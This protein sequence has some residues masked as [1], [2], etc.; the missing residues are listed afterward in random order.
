MDRTS[1][2]IEYLKRY[3]HICYI[4]AAGAN[5]KPHEEKL[6]AEM[7]EIDSLIKELKEH[8]CRRTVDRT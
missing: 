2:V 5:D 1:R 3:H 4:K 7:K 8:V 6:K